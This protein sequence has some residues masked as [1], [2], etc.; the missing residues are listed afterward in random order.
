MDITGFY[1]VSKGFTGFYWALLDSAGYPWVWTV[2]NG[3]LPSFTEF[4]LGLVGG[5]GELFLVGD[6]RRDLT[7]L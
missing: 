1:R 4:L 7:A 6:R 2:L 3:F 5:S